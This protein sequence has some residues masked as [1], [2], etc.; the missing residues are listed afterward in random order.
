[1]AASWMVATLKDD[2]W[3][4]ASWMAASWMAASKVAAFR[5]PAFVLQY[6]QNSLRRNWMLRQPLLSVYWLPK[7]PV[8]WFT[9]LFW[10]SQSD[11]LWLPTPQCAAPV[12]LR[13]CHAMPLVTR[14]FPST[15]YCECYGFESAFFT[16]ILFLLYTPSCCFQ[17]LP[18]AGSSPSKVAGLHADHRNIAD[19][20]TIVL[21]HSIQQKR[22]TGRFYLCA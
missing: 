18:G 14:R 3:M 12:W 1:M 11:Q 10:Q 13:G 2:S 21:N 17:G 6:L 8:V 5:M 15:L 19:W 9:S 4:A 16:H 20:P 7:H 22:Y